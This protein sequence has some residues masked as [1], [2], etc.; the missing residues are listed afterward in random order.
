MKRI[1]HINPQQKLGIKTILLSSLLTLDAHSSSE[2]VTQALELAT[3]LPTPTTKASLQNL[4]SLNT[5]GSL[6]FSNDQYD[7]IQDL[8]KKLRDTQKIKLLQKNSIN[9]QEFSLSELKQLVKTTYEQQQTFNSETSDRDKLAK[10]YIKDLDVMHQKALLEEANIQGENILTD[11]DKDLAAIKILFAKEKKQREKQQAARIKHEKEQGIDRE[12]LENDLLS[13]HYQAYKKEVQEE[14]EELQKMIDAFEQEAYYPKL[15]YTTKNL[16]DT[17]R[18]VEKHT[19]KAAD[20]TNLDG[21]FALFTIIKNQ[22]ITLQE[23]ILK[24]HTTVKRIHT[25]AELEQNKKLETLQQDLIR[26]QT[27]LK[28][29]SDIKPKNDHEADQK[30]QKIDTLNQDIKDITYK[31]SLAHEEK[32]KYIHEKLTKLY[33]LEK[34]VAILTQLKDIQKTIFEKFDIDVPLIFGTQKQYLKI[35]PTIKELEKVA[36]PSQPFKNINPNALEYL[37]TT[38]SLIWLDYQYLFSQINPSISIALK[39]PKEFILPAMKWAFYTAHAGLENYEENQLFNSL[40]SGQLKYELRQA[41]IFADRAN[42]SIERYELS[43]KDQPAKDLAQ[44]EA[45]A[46]LIAAHKIL[47]AKIIKKEDDA[48]FFKLQNE[49]EIAYPLLTIKNPDNQT[50]EIILNPELEKNLAQIAITWLKLAE[51]GIISS[52]TPFVLEYPTLNGTKLNLTAEDLAN[53][54]AHA[55]YLD[56]APQNKTFKAF[57]DSVRTFSFAKLWKWLADTPQYL[58]NQ[59]KGLKKSLKDMKKATLDESDL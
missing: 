20:F 27:E 39:R 17:I 16:L 10:E 5:D 31:I 42:S 1:I 52:T 38:L 59:I 26:A 32:E 24:L 43:K 28:E 58:A 37:K 3:L 49:F 21:T 18:Q 56:K 45:Q 44:Q 6:N 48:L 35:N 12:I 51:K 40:L 23:A 9:Q 29:Q 25:I 2:M 50:D 15:T 19:Q 22:L 46:L 33:G 57:K 53:Y 4:I 36:L 8:L 54:I 30:T 13:Q 41:Q 55:G 11:A 7:Q 34:N 14:T 47:F